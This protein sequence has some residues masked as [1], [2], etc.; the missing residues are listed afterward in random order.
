MTSKTEKQ[1][2]PCTQCPRKC[3]AVRSKGPGRCHVGGVPLVAS[4]APHFYEEPCISGEKGSGAVFF[5]GCPL[6]C[7]FCQNHKISRGNA[8]RGMNT[9]ELAQLFLRLQGEGVHN[10]NLVSATQFRLPVMQAV[11]AAKGAG[12]AV[13]V[14][15]NTGGY[16]NAGVAAE[17]AWE[18]DVFLTDIKFFDSNLSGRLAGAA[19]YFE[20]ALGFA[21]EACAAVGP[22]VYDGGLLQKGVIL[23]VLVLPGHA[24]DAVEILRHA[25]ALL[26]RGSFLLS[27]MRQYTPPDVPDLPK[28]LRRPLS[29]YEYEKVCGA[30]RKLGLTDGYLQS[31]ESVGEQYV[32]D[33]DAFAGEA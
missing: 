7:V 9:E 22:P 6:G 3:G 12:L 28:E 30:A 20:R 31:K 4:A 13:P 11:R 16:E 25:A 21:K 5:A 23:R 15:W 14:V 2:T 17:L 19:D 27:L 24:E 33:F 18:V 32:P 26:P 8:G 10:L 1:G 29:T